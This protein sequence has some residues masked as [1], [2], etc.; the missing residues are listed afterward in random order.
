[1]DV[2]CVGGTG[3]VGS[4]VTRALVE[5]GASVRCMTRSAD[6]AG[7]VA[8][9]IS[10]VAGDLADP[11][12]LAPAFEG[13]RRVHLVTPMHPDEAGLGRAAVDAA[14]AAG[15]ERIVY[16]SV[17][18]VEDAPHVP[19]FASKI[20]IMD[21]LIGSGI[22]WVT[23]EPNN[24]FQTDL[25]LRE[26]I[27]EMQIYPLPIGE[28]GITRVDTRDIADATV[29]ALLHDGHEGLRYPIVGPE[30][31][32][33]EQV[34]DVWGDALDGTVVYTGDDLDMWE[35][36]VRDVLPGWMVDDLRSMFAHFLDHGLIATEED[37]A[38]MSHILGHA[39]RLY[40]D[41]VAET[42]AAWS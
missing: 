34:V 9:G 18:R 25:M 30:T 36:G 14:V 26:P 4:L 1:M 32:T 31:L 27:M 16:Q 40:A 39:P 28:V 41:F 19:H 23:I 6:L 8:D 20:A 29:S 11:S 10:Y 33:G 3:N 5:Q 42:V 13:A 37:Y 35:E 2:L 12:S 38:T 15:V 21:E 17:H 7:S 22:P 24:F